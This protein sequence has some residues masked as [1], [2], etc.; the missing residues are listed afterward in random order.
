MQC[1]CVC[2]IFG[3]QKRVLGSLELELQAVMSH[4][5]YMLGSKFL[6]SA[7]TDDVSK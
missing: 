2:F 4:L 3:Y 1:V 6:S 7:K 5:T